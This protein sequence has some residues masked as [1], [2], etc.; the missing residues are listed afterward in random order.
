MEQNHAKTW[1]ERPTTQTGEW[2]WLRHV[3]KLYQTQ[4]IALKLC[5]K[6]TAGQQQHCPAKHETIDQSLIPVAHSCTSSIVMW[7]FLNLKVFFLQLFGGRKRKQSKNLKETSSNETKCQAKLKLSFQALNCQFVFA[8]F[9]HGTQLG[10]PW[11]VCRRH[12]L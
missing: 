2:D 4:V 7:F 8:L 12:P 11:D 3:A 10:S 5:C 9:S 6:L 1:A